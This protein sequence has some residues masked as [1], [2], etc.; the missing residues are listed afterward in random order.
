M[1]KC[2][3]VEDICPL[4]VLLDPSH[5]LSSSLI[6][7]LDHLS[8]RFD[9][10]ILVENH[11]AAL[12]NAKHD[13]SSA[14]QLLHQVFHV[15][16]VFWCNDMGENAPTSVPKATDQEPTSSMENIQTSRN[17]LHSLAI[18]WSYPHISN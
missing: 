8:R 7:V 17:A 10:A 13:H 4:E 9:K 18:S 11:P 15:R 1:V 3:S 14:T 6:P 2:D 12:V 5:H 16:A